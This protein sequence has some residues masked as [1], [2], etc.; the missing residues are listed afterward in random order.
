MPR[1]AKVLLHL[2]Q[3]TFLR[4]Y[5]AVRGEKNLWYSWPALVLIMIGI[6]TVGDS[7]VC[8]G[9]TVDARGVKKVICVLHSIYRLIDFIMC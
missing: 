3:G 4:R 2:R 1:M 6:I 9:Q 7:I 8:S 5:I